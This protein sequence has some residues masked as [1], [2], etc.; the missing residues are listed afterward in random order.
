MSSLLDF[1][2]DQVSIIRFPV[3]ETEVAKELIKELK[4]TRMMTQKNTLMRNR[5]GL[6]LGL[7]EGGTKLRSGSLKQG[8][9][10]AWPRAPQIGCLVFEYQNPKFRTHLMDC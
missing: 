7:S 9:L 8:F 3:M 5:T 4:Q 2:V 1:Q 6:D 10:G